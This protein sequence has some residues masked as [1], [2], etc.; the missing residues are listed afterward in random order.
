MRTE[1]AE[2]TP[3][4]T[5]AEKRRK[6]A[7]RARCC[8]CRRETPPNAVSPFQLLKK[9]PSFLL[10]RVTLCRHR[11]LT[12]QLERV[13]LSLTSAEVRSPR[14]FGS[15]QLIPEKF[16]LLLR[17]DAVERQIRSLERSNPHLPRCPRLILTPQASSLELWLNRSK[18]DRY[19]KVSLRGEEVSD[20]DEYY[21][22]LQAGE[23]AR[24]PSPK[25]E[26]QQLKDLVSRESSL[27]SR[28]I[29]SH[30]S[31]ARGN[32]G[33]IFDLLKENGETLEAL[34]SA[35]S[36]WHV[37]QDEFMREL[38]QRRRRGQDEGPSPLRRRRS[39]GAQEQEI[40]LDGPFFV[41]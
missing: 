18:A 10:Q 19:L 40:T 41:I 25:P 22:Q 29:D 4:H 1:N 34:S 31:M 33:V 23:E 28:K 38:E 5:I 35:T 37:R 21:K 32:N 6:S 26:I 12:V 15:A 39:T 2:N 24:R 7:R 13:V 27:L 9:V 20:L 11:L 8:R 3:V 17:K 14:R 16:S 36:E 30:F